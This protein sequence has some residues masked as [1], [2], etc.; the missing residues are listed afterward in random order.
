MYVCMYVCV[1]L[2]RVDQINST[3]MTNK[4][5]L[6]PHTDQK[7]RHDLAHVRHDKL[8]HDLCM[9]VCMYV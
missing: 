3:I 5:R 8:R 6:T 9:Y 4:N 2:F 7:L 1:S